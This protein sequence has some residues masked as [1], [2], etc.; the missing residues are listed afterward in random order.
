MGGACDSETPKKVFLGYDVE[1]ETW[2]AAD[3]L[4]ATF[5]KEQEFEMTGPR[6]R[7]CG[8]CRGPM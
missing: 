5:T 4:N 8:R 6:K 1:H 3:I 2:L 7:L